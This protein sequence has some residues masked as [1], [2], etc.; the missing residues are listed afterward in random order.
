MQLAAKQQQEQRALKATMAAQSLRASRLSAFF[1]SPS[2]YLFV[3]LSL[4]LRLGQLIYGFQFSKPLTTCSSSSSSST[5]HKAQGC[6]NAVENC[7]AARGT[8]R[9]S[10]PAYLKH[11]WRRISAPFG[12]KQR[13]WADCAK[14]MAAKRT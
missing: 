6:K 4:A 12:R 10:L 8:R 13:A 3:P 1:P 14:I 9:D 7:H 11:N 2:L 5:R